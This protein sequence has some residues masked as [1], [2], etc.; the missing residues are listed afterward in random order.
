MLARCKLVQDTLHVGNPG[1]HSRS[2]S[3]SSWQPATPPK[4]ASASGPALAAKHHKTHPT[5]H[6]T[7]RSR[8]LFEAPPAASIPAKPAS[9]G[10]SSSSSSSLAHSEL[11]DSRQQQQQAHK[12]SWSSAVDLNPGFSFRPGESVFVASAACLMGWFCSHS[13]GSDQLQF[14]CCTLTHVLLTYRSLQVHQSAQQL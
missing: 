14:F 1:S 9:G 4:Q 10:N 3:S 12:A 7:M 11:Q 5:M 8:L 2:S 13:E 6:L